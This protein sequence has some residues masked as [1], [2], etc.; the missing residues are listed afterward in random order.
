MSF[1]EREERRMG[2]IKMEVRRSGCVNGF[3]GKWCLI[4][5]IGGEMRGVW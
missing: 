1:G 3:K 5:K 2:G 4:N